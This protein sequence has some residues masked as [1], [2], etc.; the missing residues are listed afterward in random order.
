MPCSRI[1]SVMTGCQ[2][3]TGYQPGTSGIPSVRRQARNGKERMPVTS[4]RRTGSAGMLSGTTRSKRS[5]SCV[6]VFRFGVCVPDGPL[7]AFT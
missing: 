5:E 7:N 4:V 1:T 6:R 3:Q 2:S